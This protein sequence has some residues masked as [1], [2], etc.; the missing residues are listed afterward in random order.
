MGT[1]TNPMNT[2]EIN[3]RSYN[4]NEQR[5]CYNS[6]CRCVA[7]YTYSSPAPNSVNEME[8]DEEEAATDTDCGA[9][10]VYEP[11]ITWLND[12]IRPPHILIYACYTIHLHIL[13]LT[14]EL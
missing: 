9:A 12:I 2:L 3:I 8:T 4:F 10:N 5:P 7:V 11:F 1:V 13:E 14:F 6:H